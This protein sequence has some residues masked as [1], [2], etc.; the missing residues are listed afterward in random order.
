MSKR[1]RN[2]LLIGGGSAV[3]LL[4]ILF[5]VYV[6]F[7]RGGGLSGAV[8][9][10]RSSEAARQAQTTNQFA[11]AGEAP[12]PDQYG[13]GSSGAVDAASPALLAPQQSAS[14]NADVEQIQ[15]LII[16]TGS[17]AVSVSDT[18][19]ARNQIL[20]LVN[21]M[22]PQ[23]AFVVSVNES[24]GGAG[25]TPYINMVIRVPATQFSP[26]MDAVAKL[27]AEG[28]T[29]QRSETAQDVTDQYVDVKAR[30]DSMELA[31][32]RLQQIMAE[33]QNT[34]DLLQAESLLTQREADIE[35]LKGRVQFLEQSAALSEI[36]ISLT[37]YI[38]SQPVNTSWQPGET[39]RRAFNDLLDSLRGFADFLIYFAIAVLPWLVIAG[40]IIYGIVRFI[41][42]RVRRNQK[43]QAILAQPEEQ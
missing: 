20:G 22:T 10:T 18:Y 15:R 40:L 12:A 37:P 17:V 28:T 42:G 23:G 9:D 26:T 8:G 38:L 35:A 7:S 2:W 13:G 32:T 43:K 34:S 19:N 5:V 30:L 1:L 25:V 14:T 41:I 24:G 29:P 36:T 3:G 21:Q 33:A 39:L 6:I 11:V 31:R 27:A 16:R 4:V